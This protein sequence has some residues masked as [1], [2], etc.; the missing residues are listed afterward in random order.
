MADHSLPTLVTPY[1]TFLSS[2]SDRIKDSMLANDP[3]SVTVTNPP[4]GTVRWTS[5]ASRFEK[6]NGSAWVVLSSLYAIAISG[7]AA[8]ATTATNVAWAGIT[9]KPTTLAGFGITDAAPLASPALTGT[10]TTGTFEI[11][12]RGMP[13]V[14]SVATA[15]LTGRG[16][17]YQQ[18]GPITIPASVFAS[19]DAF[20]IYC[21]SPSSLV[22]TQGAGLTLRFAGTATV[23]N[24]T[25]AGRGWCTVWFNSATE[26]I[27]NGGGLT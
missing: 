6:W 23:G 10:P 11:G 18:T 3:A 24:R 16:K 27:I 9:S 15:A 7:N 4:T 19:G 22:I 5:A 8:T 20:S 1:A 12:F 21:H 2:L 25:L 17:C 14:L 26:A 13:M